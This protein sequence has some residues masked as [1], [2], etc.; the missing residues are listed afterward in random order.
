MSDDIE[1]KSVEAL[2]NAFLNG[3]LDHYKGADSEPHPA[4]VLEVLN[5]LAATVVW[6]LKGTDFSPRAYA[7]YRDSLIAQID[8]EAGEIVDG[9]KLA[10][11]MK[12]AAGLVDAMVK[13]SDDGS[14]H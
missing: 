10:R 8:L 9:L 13:K 14:V 12:A 7:F 4:R 2:T 3:I 1:R 5:A 6:A 11:K